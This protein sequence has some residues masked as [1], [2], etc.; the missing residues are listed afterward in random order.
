[1]DQNLILLQLLFS[2]SWS[3]TYFSCLLKITPFTIQCNYKISDFED[4][5][6]FFV[7][8]RQAIDLVIV[9]TLTNGIVF[10]LFEFC[11]RSSFHFRNA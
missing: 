8:A 7:V 11:K 6:D 1:M 5:L 3:D 2:Q 9:V 4:H 10:D